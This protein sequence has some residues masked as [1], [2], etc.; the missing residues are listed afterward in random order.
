MYQN[1]NSP[2][3]QNSTNEPNHADYLSHKPNIDPPKK[4]NSTQKYQQRS[5]SQRLRA[6][7]RNI[8]ILV[9]LALLI[10]SSVFAYIVLFPAS[11]FS[12]FVVDNTPLNQLFSLNQNNTTEGVTI[13]NVKP[14]NI[15]FGLEEDNL[16]SQQSTVR[17][18]SQTLPSVLS[19]RVSDP[20]NSQFRTSADGTGFVVS[21]GGLVVT[22][23]HVVSRAC[24]SS[25]PISITAQDAAANAYEL[26]LVSIDPI[27]DIAILQINNPG[28]A[29][30]P[31]VIG[32]SDEL[33]LGEEV[34]AIGNVLG[35]LN[36][37]VTRGIVSG[38][39]RTLETGLVDTCTQNNII[40]DGLIQ[41]DA[42]INKGNSGGPLFDASG[43]L[44]GMNTFGT[45]EAQSV[46]FAIPSAAII[47]ALRSYNDNGK[48]IRPRL[49]IY[50][51]VITPVD[52]EDLSWLPVDDGEI[53]TAPEGSA[54]VEDGSS[55]AAAGLRAGDIIVE[56]NGQ[57]VL[58]GANNRRPL[59]RLL[60][61]YKPDDE[62]TLTV[63]KATGISE[64]VPQ[65]ATQSE[66]VTVKL[67][68]ISF[69]NFAK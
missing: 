23:R 69:D 11:Q 54:A 3:P 15:F 18:V 62:I 20:S 51:Q 48:I 44:V 6:L 65:Y 41:T 22:N 37:T 8:G 40:A 64:G 25:I 58:Y 31:V 36:N 16:S 10:I 29:I 2:Y 35:Q 45:T 4:D 53:L 55:A 52:R 28:D 17:L 56:V 39:D 61:Q 66:T 9:V 27:E 14:G 1:N 24:S 33:L 13:Q 57:A 30:S 21:S 38:I 19:I 5:F 34:V 47:Y 67:G 43:Q 42:A 26:S 68:G 50:S 7:I 49:G 59:R 60:S 32:N 63:R 12:T 46:G